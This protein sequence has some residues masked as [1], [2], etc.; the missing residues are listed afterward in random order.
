MWR[1]AYNVNRR[2]WG[3]FYR[4]A[5][6]IMLLSVLVDVP[7]L[8]KDTSKP[9][10]LSQIPAVLNMLG[11]GQVSGYVA[12]CQQ[13]LA[14]KKRQGQETIPDNLFRGCSRLGN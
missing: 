9:E 13:E 6:I 5:A 2:F 10:S 3:G 12:E 14:S 11:G 1:C 7:D 8:W 4:A